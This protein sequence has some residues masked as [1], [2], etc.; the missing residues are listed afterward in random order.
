MVQTRRL[1]AQWRP[2]AIGA[3]LAI[4]AVLVAKA[5]GSHHDPRIYVAGA[6]V[7]AVTVYVIWIVPPA[8]SVSAGVVLSM[9]GSNWA[10]L[11]LPSN[12]A[13]DRAVLTLAIIAIAVRAPGSR[14]R[15]PI[16]FRPIYAVMYIAG[17]YAIGSAIADHT[18]SQH[19]AIF[20]LLDR[21]Q[22]FQWL[23][24]II[25]PAA[26]S[27]REDRRV[28]LAT[29]V[30]MGVYLGF[31]GIFEIV[32]PHA[33]VFP[34]YINNP[35]VGIHYGRARGPFTEADVMGLALYACLLA[36]VVAHREWSS[37]WPRVAAKVAFVVCCISLLLTLERTIWVAVAITVPFTLIVVRELRR[38]IL[39]VLAGVA[40][41]VGVAFS[42]GTVRNK[43][44][45]RTSSQ[46]IGT[47]Q[48]RQALDDA[49]IAMVEARPLFGFG[50]E[51]FLVVAPNYFKTSDAYSIDAVANNPVHDVYA[52]I[53][54]EL[55]LVGL[56]LWLTIL[57][58]C[59]GG[60]AFSRR[61]PPDLRP[62]KIALGSLLLLWLI[63]AISTPLASNFQ[64]L[65]IWIWAAVVAGGETSG[66]LYR[67]RRPSRPRVRYRP[68]HRARTPVRPVTGPSV[69]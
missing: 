62:W 6:L 8:W 48:N 49:A 23:V 18:I 16:R 65:V 44:L 43:L 45:V 41:L 24:F 66:S 3:P 9:F 55:G 46:S 21:M 60:A 19:A 31:T 30:G 4:V 15:P 36:S 29:F 52:S 47:L 35:A 11:G 56:A 61:G 57:L 39:P 40:L 20:D 37:K 59:V 64:S 53:A 58:V 34:R 14:N 26:F 1:S 51:Q 2:V 33:F 17:A 50:W 69:P 25:V 63:A 12:I 22:I 68:N 10:A 28:I 42:I 5:T 27:T 32:G 13:P 7:A 67:D 54:A 38:Y